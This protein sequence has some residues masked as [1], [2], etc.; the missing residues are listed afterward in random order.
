M[1]HIS[2]KAEYAVVACAALAKSYG[3]DNPLG[4]IS[5][6]AEEHGGSLRV[7]SALGKGSEV[8]IHLPRTV[9]AR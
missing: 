7:V 6:I 5:K 2:S 9:A 8:H 1:S 4:K 3:T